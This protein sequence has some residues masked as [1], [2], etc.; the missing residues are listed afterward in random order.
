MIHSLLDDRQH[1]DDR[2]QVGCAKDLLCINQK[3]RMIMMLRPH[4]KP[5]IELL[6]QR[7]LIKRTRLDRYRGSMDQASCRI[8]MK[9]IGRKRQLV[10]S[11]SAAV[12]HKRFSSLPVLWRALLSD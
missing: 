5:R 1:P 7:E 2:K 10:Q 3:R 6:Y 8:P 4:P 9:P 12:G 11:V